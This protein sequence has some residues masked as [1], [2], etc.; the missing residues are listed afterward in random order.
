MTLWDST[1]RPA[2]ATTPFDINA[3]E[4]LE[5]NPEEKHEISPS[6]NSK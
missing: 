6:R 4:N 5:K 3:K 2:V 1:G